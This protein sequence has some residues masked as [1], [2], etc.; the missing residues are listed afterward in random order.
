MREVFF[1]VATIVAIAPAA[2]ADTVALP[3]GAS[4]DVPEGWKVETTQNGYMMASGDEALAIYLLDTGD[5][6]VDDAW[7]SLTGVVG[8]SIGDLA[9]GAAKQ[10]RLGGMDA[11]MATA[12]G[13]AGSD[14]LGL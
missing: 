4:I 9:V 2:R 12:T 14:E 13:H 5:A 11:R 8:E 6:S 1:A 10:G 3:V 7:K